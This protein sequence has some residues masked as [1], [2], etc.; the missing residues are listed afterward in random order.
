M[1]CF[2]RK[3]L[4]RIL[5]YFEVSQKYVITPSVEAVSISS[6]DGGLCSLSLT[7]HDFSSKGMEAGI[8]LNMYRLTSSWFYFLGLFIHFAVI[9]CL[10]FLHTILNN[11]FHRLVSR[12]HVMNTSIWWLFQTIY[13]PSWRTVVAK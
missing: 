6:W 12:F 7:C 2:V 1:L 11:A 5:I 4:L 9:L 13:S 3:F 8:T 10:Y